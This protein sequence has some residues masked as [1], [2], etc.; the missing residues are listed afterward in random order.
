M[1]SFLFP[2]EQFKSQP[3]GSIAVTLSIHKDSDF[4]HSGL[5]FRDGDQISFLHLASYKSL[6]CE[7]LYQIAGDYVFFIYT[8]FSH[9]IKTDPHFF[10]RKALI[11]YLKAIYEK[12][13]QTIPYS[14]LYKKVPFDKERKFNPELGQIGL[15]CSTFVMAALEDN[16]IF[17]CNKDSWPARHDDVEIRKRIISIYNEDPRVPK[18]HLAIME[19]ELYC[20]RFRPEEVLCASGRFPVPCNFK[21]TVECSEKAL[22]NIKN[23]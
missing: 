4:L 13:K 16:G 7:D 11:A 22:S 21:D 1:P 15:T 19:S 9:L 20:V 17:L 5:A 2:I 3:K 18:E 6:R 12:N 10:R 14:F 23:K 8:N